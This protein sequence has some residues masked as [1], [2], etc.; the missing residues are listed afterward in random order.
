[1]SLRF[2]LEKITDDKTHTSVLFQIITNIALLFY[3]SRGTAR[4]ALPRRGGYF[5]RLRGVGSQNG[6]F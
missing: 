6:V 1:M 5:K 4:Q 3:Q 2:H